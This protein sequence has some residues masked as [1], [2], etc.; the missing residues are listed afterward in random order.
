M[1][2]KQEISC[3]VGLPTLQKISLILLAISIILCITCP[4]AENLGNVFILIALP[5]LMT[6]YFKHRELLCNPY[7]KATPVRLVPKFTFFLCALSGSLY[8][9]IS[10]HDT[11]CQRA[12]VVFL[13]VVFGVSL[14]HLFHHFEV[15]INL[16]VNTRIDKKASSVQE[17]WNYLF[18]TPQNKMS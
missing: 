13:N 1:K 6:S 11:W 17:E 8:S 18:E 5:A 3:A 15:V 12:V 4:E 16:D 14:S 7:D 9:I 2:T 10:V